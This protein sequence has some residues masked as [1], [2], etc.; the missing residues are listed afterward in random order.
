MKYLPAIIVIACAFIIS[1][2][3]KHSP[4]G[5][6][7]ADGILCEVDSWDIGIV[8]KICTP[9]QKVIYLPKTFGNEQLPV[10]FAAVNCDLRF[11]VAMTNGAVSCIYGPIT[12][13]PS[14]KKQ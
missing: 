5:H 13:T 9:G 6:D 10:I 8:K 4:V 14:D 1:S 2:C 11:A 12:E 7:V 3:S